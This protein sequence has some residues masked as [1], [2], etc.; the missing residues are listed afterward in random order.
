MLRWCL[1]EARGRGV[2]M[3][4]LL[5]NV[6]RR[7]LRASLTIFGITIGVLALVVMGA[8]AEKLT[9]FT[10]G[11]GAYY[12]QK[13]VVTADGGWGSSL[14]PT[15]R[16]SDIQRVPGVASVSVTAGSSLK[17]E[18]GSASLL[19]IQSNDGREKSYESSTLEMTEGRLVGNADRGVVTLGQDV[20]TMFDAGV[21]DTVDIH[22]KDYRVVG[23]LDTTLSFPDS[24]AYLSIHDAQHVIHEDLPGDRRVTATPETIASALV[25]YPEPGVD[26]QALARR[27][28]RYVPGVKASGPGDWEQQVTI[29]ARMLTSV[30]YAIGAVALIV[31]SLSVVNTMTMSISER[32]REI[33]I[34]K[35]LGAS[36]GQVL[37][38]FV[39]EAG[40]MGF[41]GGLVGLGLGALIALVGNAAGAT[42]GSPM[43]VLTPR[44]A[45]GSVGLALALGMLGGLYPAYRAAQMNP[46][47]ALRYE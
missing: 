46:V 31:S 14:L 33:G 19:T 23:V 20:A 12:A 7:R 29:P 25:A 16:R 42:I 36:D 35:A 17:P 11:M 45:I 1:L 27:I 22:G 4:R 43:F 44:L 10:V 40:A 39:S 8:V 13:V 15:R 41:I 2:L 37:V 32:T 30:V 3:V 38:Q 47:E 24:A 6:F 21:G 5:R 26:P 28:E 34:R 9:V 18:A